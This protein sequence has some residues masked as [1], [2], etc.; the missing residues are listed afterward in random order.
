[1]TENTFK[2]DELG[3]FRIRIVKDATGDATGKVE[4]LVGMYDIGNTDESVRTGNL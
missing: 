2:F 4:K 3:Y 1:M